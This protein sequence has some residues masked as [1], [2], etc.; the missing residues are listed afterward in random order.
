MPEEAAAQLADAALH[1]LDADPMFRGALA[2]DALALVGDQGPEVR[3]GEGLKERIPLKAPRVISYGRAAISADGALAALPYRADGGAG[4]NDTVGL[5]DAR[6]GA[7]LARLGLGAGSRILGVT[8]GRDGKLAAIFGDSPRRGALLR[9]YRLVGKRRKPGR[10]LAWSSKPHQTTFSAAISPGGKTVAL[11]AGEELL[12]WRLGSKA[13]RPR[14]RPTAAIK[15]LFPPLLRGPGVKL[16]GAHQL[17]FSPDGARLAS[18]HALGVVG[19]ATWEVKEL[20]PVA[21]NARPTAGGPMRQVSWGSEG[22]LWLLTAG[23]S[24]R[25]TVHRPEGIRFVP[26]RV[27]GE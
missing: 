26:A 25:I 11:G 12:L 8:L 13:V 10:L 3:R 23:H 2:A 7:R 27:L 1:T 22:K 15:A 21:W 17:A 20:R 14:S 5:F 19:V 4:D 18:L 16:P 6:T 24:P 9:V